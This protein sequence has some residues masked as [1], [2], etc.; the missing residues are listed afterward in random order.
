MQRHE[1]QH[2]IRAVRVLLIWLGF[3]L[4][5]GLRFGN[6]MEERKV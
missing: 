5:R 2:L 3:C 1:L 6:E 4:R